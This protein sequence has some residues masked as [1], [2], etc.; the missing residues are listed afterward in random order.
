MERNVNQ[1]PETDLTRKIQASNSF[2][3]VL[4]IFLALGC[5]GILLIGG[6]IIWAG[7]ATVQHVADLGADPRIKE[8]VENLKNEIPKIPAAV[9]VG[10]W[11]KVQDLLNVQVWLETP[12]AENVEALKE[13]CWQNNRQTD[14]N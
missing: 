2:K 5:V 4:K 8:Q 10:C 13:A 6:L 7:V 11:E 12:V 3:R 9:K 1:Q 14:E